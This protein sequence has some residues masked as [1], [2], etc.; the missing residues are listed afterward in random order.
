MGQPQTVSSRAMTGQGTS[1]TNMVAI[2]NKAKTGSGVFPGTNYA[3]LSI[4]SVGYTQGG[5]VDATTAGKVADLAD[6][7]VQFDA[8]NLNAVPL[9]FY[10][11]LPA[12]I[13]SATVFDQSVW[14]TYVFCRAQAPGMGGAYSGRVYATGPSYPWQFNG[15][16]QIH[17]GDYGSSRWGEIEGYARWLVQDKG[18]AWTPLWRPL[19]GGA[20][21]RSGQTITVPFA[22]P[23]GPDFAN[24]PMVWQNNPVDGIKDWPQKGFHVRRGGVELTVT[25]AI[26]GMTVQL[27]VSET[28]NPGDSLEVSYAWYGPGGPAYAAS[29]PGVG[30]NLVMNGPP[31]VLYPN[32][33]NGAGKTIDDLGVAASLKRCSHGR[34]LL[35]GYSVRAIAARRGGA[36]ND[37]ARR[38]FWR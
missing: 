34:T 1:W 21:V 36:S 26:A 15:A 9:K 31:S 4:S 6:M 12:A 35:A 30:G 17:T 16:D 37:Y 18:I 25:P 19:T 28:I 2:L 38:R 7:T 11:G 29:M 33:W 22:R 13:T 5:S 23:A 32:G 14:G 3:N 27:A 20:L 24:A 8:L 10:Y